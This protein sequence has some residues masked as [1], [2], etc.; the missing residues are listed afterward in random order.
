M[1]ESALIR[2]LLFSALF[3]SFHQ[4]Q[5]E[6]RRRIARELHDSVGQSLADDHEEAASHGFMYQRGDR[7]N[8]IFMVIGSVSMKLR[9]DSAG[10]TISLFPVYAAPAV[11]DPR[12]PLHL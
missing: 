10:K 5:D 11:P 9:I 2:Q 6:E 4:S 12:P 8:Y 7:I 3:S 1:G